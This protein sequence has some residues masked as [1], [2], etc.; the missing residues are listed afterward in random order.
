VVPEVCLDQVLP[1]LVVTTIVP[2]APTD[3]QSLPLTHDVAYRSFVVP[4]GWTVQEEAKAGVASATSVAR[5]R[6]DI[7]KS[8]PSRDGLIRAHAETPAMVSSS[9]LQPRT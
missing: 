6:A 2:E 3:Q 9:A 4:D 1:P 7:P 5:T 8:R